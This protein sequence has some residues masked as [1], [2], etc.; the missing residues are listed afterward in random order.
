MRQIPIVSSTLHPPRDTNHGA[1]ALVTGGKTPSITRSYGQP[2]GLGFPVAWSLTEAAAGS[3]ID[4]AVDVEQSPQTRP[5]PHRRRGEPPRKA[6]PA[7]G[8]VR[9][10]GE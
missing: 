2:F 3:L 6:R 9:G 1:A 7:V 4:D 10:S 5:V 8:E